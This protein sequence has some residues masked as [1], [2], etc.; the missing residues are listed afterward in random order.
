MRSEAFENFEWPGAVGSP[1]AV[2]ETLLPLMKANGW[3]GA[4]RWAKRAN[5]I[6]PTIVGG[7]KRH[8]G[9]D[10]GPTRARQAWLALGVDGR[11]IANQAPASEESITHIPKLTNP[12]VALI[13]GFD[14]DWEFAGLKTSTYRQIGNAFPAPVAKS[15]GLAI[16]RALNMSARS[17]FRLNA[18]A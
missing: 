6:G 15:V 5:G 10:L 17:K 11:G 7:S 16:G 14:A 2:G 9:A 4:D 3:G 1:A 8:G 12:M 13:Q 18:V